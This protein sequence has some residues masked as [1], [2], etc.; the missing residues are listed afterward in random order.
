[1]NSR[2]IST[3]RKIS[4]EKFLIF[5]TTCLC[6]F[7]VVNTMIKTTIHVQ[8]DYL[9]FNMDGT[10]SRSGQAVASGYHDA[11]ASRQRIR[12]SPAVAEMKY[13]RLQGSASNR[14]YS[15]ILSTPTLTNFLER[16]H[17]EISGFFDTC[18]AG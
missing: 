18:S 16:S 17:I 9:L 2:G 10:T 14:N 15:S 4:K 11:I 8:S 5:E 12:R 7:Q 1:M 6:T 13:L 3:N